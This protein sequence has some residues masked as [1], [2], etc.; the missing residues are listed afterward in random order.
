MLGKNGT[1]ILGF[2]CLVATAAAAD[3]VQ[4]QL[5]RVL[6]TPRCKPMFFGPTFAEMDGSGVKEPRPDYVLWDPAMA[7]PMVFKD[8]RTSIAF[9][10]ESDG[11][12]VAAIDKEGNLLWVRNPFEDA[13]LC[14][15][16]NARP[17]ISSMAEIEITAGMVDSLKSRRANPNHQFLEVKFDSSQFGVL[18][19][20]TGDFI[21]WG[22]N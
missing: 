22:Q 8:S 12:H 11:R 6:I 16:R 17:S 13:N 5:V 2:V 15:Y 18:D 4:V 10:V 14:P 7:K 21:P 9:Y 1:A 3:P 19:E 20:D